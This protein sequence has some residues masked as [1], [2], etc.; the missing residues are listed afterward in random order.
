MAQQQ[1]QQ[2]A[3]PS[4]PKLTPHQL[5]QRDGRMLIMLDW[6]QK[7]L[8]DIVPRTLTAFFARNHEMLEELLADRRKFRYLFLW[9]EK[10]PPPPP[11]EKKEKD[12]E[13][14]EENDDDDDDDFDG[15]VSDEVMAR[16][17]MDVDRLSV[18]QSPLGLRVVFFCRRRPG[19]MSLSTSD[20]A[21]AF[22]SK[23]LRMGFVARD[24]V[25]ELAQTF[26]QEASSSSSSAAAAASAAL[27]K[28]GG[29]AWPRLGDFLALI[30]R[31]AAHHRNGNGGDGGDG[32]LFFPRLEQVFA[33]PFA[34]VVELT[35]EEAE[36]LKQSCRSWVGLYVHT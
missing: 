16:F 14:E 19:Y 30:R 4:Q 20:A 29:Y 2:Q 8:P 31:Y 34:T 17:H 35:R 15:F 1:P 33:V 5:L 23:F 7:C 25:V 3:Q 27:A 13:E 26:Q 9:A 28:R 32:E 10:P 36:D 6:T 11:K 12:D 22:T 24:P 21:D 18:P